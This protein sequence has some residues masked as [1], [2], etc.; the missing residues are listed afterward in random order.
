[1]SHILVSRLAAPRDVRL[2]LNEGTLTLFYTCSLTHSVPV[3]LTEEHSL[4]WNAP[5]V[6]QVE[7]STNL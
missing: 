5:A 4:N 2:R 1:M 3:P 7:K 6:D